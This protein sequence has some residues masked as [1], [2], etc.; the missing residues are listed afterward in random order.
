MGIARIEKSSIE[1]NGVG[2]SNCLSSGSKPQGVFL[3]YA[4][5]LNML[6]S[7]IQ[8]ARGRCHENQRVKTYITNPYVSLMIMHFIHWKKAISGLPKSIWYDTSSLLFRYA[9]E[10]LT[11]I[12]F[13]LI[14]RKI[15]YDYKTQVKKLHFGWVCAWYWYMHLLG[16][17]IY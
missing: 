1:L 16:L 10:R 17:S 2:F 13:F 14:S 9:P 11:M 3:H 15:D 7:L 6:A 8:R 4:H 12:F 5:Y